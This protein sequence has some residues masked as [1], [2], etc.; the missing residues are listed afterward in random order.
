MRDSW[1]GF[2]SAPLFKRRVVDE[3]NLPLIRAFPSGIQEDVKAV[4]ACLPLDPHSL[5]T[6]SYSVNV[7]G[8]T[9]WIPYRVYHDISQIRLRPLSRF[10]VEILNCILSRH[11]DG[12]VRQR[13]LEQILGSKHMW[14]PAFVIQLAG[15]YVV[16]LLELIDR[17]LD[18]FDSEIY[19]EFVM[20]NP[21]FLELT[22][23]R[24]ESYWDCYYRRR[25]NRAEYVA[26]RILR[27]L[28][29]LPNKTT[30]QID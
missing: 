28:Q 8:E 19:S 23:Q 1:T 11:A 10:Q 4:L 18:S 27:Y 26:F 30:H 3:T 29:N 21:K 5:R 13:S 16:E 17:N 25:T 22:A 6:G 9:L 12:F 24:M 14:V 7:R 20:Y 15:E 2:W